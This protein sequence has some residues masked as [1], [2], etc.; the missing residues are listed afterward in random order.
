MSEIPNIDEPIY[1]HNLVG[2]MWA[3]DDGYGPNA[4]SVRGIDVFENDLTDMI[5]VVGRVV[6]EISLGNMRIIT[7]RNRLG[8][9]YGQVE[10][11]IEGEEQLW[12]KVCARLARDR[13]SNYDLSEIGRLK[14]DFSFNKNSYRL[15]VGDHLTFYSLKGCA[16]FE[17]NT[18]PI[19]DAVKVAWELPLNLVSDPPCLVKDDNW[20]EL[21]T[22]SEFRSI[23]VLN[24]NDCDTVSEFVNANLALKNMIAAN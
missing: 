14:R 21:I 12:M 10:V 24:P 8:T 1:V 18:N 19:E 3:I 7:C 15:K 22:C 4:D 11:R 17:I 20:S 23:M 9:V 16:R 2:R 13:D 5:D 6:P